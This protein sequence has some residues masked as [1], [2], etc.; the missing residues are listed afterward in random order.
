MASMRGLGSGTWLWIAPLFFAGVA[1]VLAKAVYESGEW[2]FVVT[3]FALVV[4][5]FVTWIW[6]VYQAWRHPK[7]SHHWR[8]Q[9]YKVG[10][11]S[12]AQR[13][14]GSVG[15]VL[16]SECDHEIFAVRAEVVEP[17]GSR[18]ECSYQISAGRVVINERFEVGFYPENFRG[19]RPLVAD[20]PYEVVWYGKRKDNSRWMEIARQAFMPLPRFLK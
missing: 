15:F 18:S 1:A 3:I 20:Q 6:P 16:R 7:R 12:Q 14:Y 5:F 19:A 13:P 8:S 9:V 2:V 10:G 17:D 4:A 11:L